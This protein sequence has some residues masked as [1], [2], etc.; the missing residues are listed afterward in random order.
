MKKVL[1]SLTLVSFDSSIAKC[2]ICLLISAGVLVYYTALQSNLS[3]DMTLPLQI[4]EASSVLMYLITFLDIIFE[5]LDYQE[6][7][8]TIISLYFLISTYSLFTNRKL[9]ENEDILS[10]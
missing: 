1:V 3:S 4:L 2:I 10:D 8:W 6:Y 7:I 5:E 9:T